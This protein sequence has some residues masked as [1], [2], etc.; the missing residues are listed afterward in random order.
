M[1]VLQIAKRLR[2]EVSGLRFADPV[3]H[4]YNPL[5]YAW[6]LHKQ[7]LQ[8][9]ARNGVQAIWVGMNPGPWGMA[10]T[11]VPFGEVGMVRD[12]LKLDGKVEQ[13]KSL[14]PKRPI[15]GLDC[16]RSEVSGRR[17]W[18]WA[19]NFFDS[20]DSFFDRFFVFNWCPLCFMEESGKNRTP[21]K[22]HI[23][24]R[25]PLRKVCDRALI[26]TV[27]ALQP[28]MVV[29]V[30][31]FARDQATRILRDVD[32]EIGQILH[33]SPA[34]PMANRGWAEQAERQLQELGLLS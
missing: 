23:A 29:G 18:T 31:K 21:D 34:S 4:V 32:I 7:Y 6:D 20:A 25:E 13:P 27:Q 33:P 22:L 19:S 5:E 12:W 26:E 16:P 9:Y 30:G 14:H 8:R 11:G 24:E 15:Q 1:E 3:T 17:L 10:Q 28:K 2:E